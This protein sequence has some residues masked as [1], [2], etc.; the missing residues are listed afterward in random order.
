M[1]TRAGYQATRGDDGT[2]T[3]HRVPIF[4][5][6]ARGDMTFDRAW[7]EAAVVKAQQA[8]RE[9]Y[10]PPLH[11]RH[12]EAATEAADAVRAAGFFRITGVEQMTFKGAPRLAVFADL[13]ITDPAAQADVLAKRLPYRSVEIFDVGAPAIDSLALLDHEAPFLELPMLMVSQVAEAPQSSGVARATMSLD[14]IDTVAATFRRGKRAAILM[15][16]ET[17]ADEIKK[18]DDKPDEKQSAEGGADVGAI[19]KAI[20]SGAISVKDMDAIVAAIQEQA[21]GS[22]QEP[23]EEGAEAAVPSG[24][25]SMSKDATTMTDESKTALAKLA[26]ENE[27]LRA[28][29]DAIEG[30]SK[31]AKA[32]GAAMKRLADRPLGSGIEERLTKFHREHGEKAFEEHV[33]A[34]EQAVGVEPRADAAR[35]AAFVAQA[36]KVPEVAMKWQK[37]GVEAVDRAAKFAREWEYLR[38]RTRLTQE[39]YVANNMARAFKAA[40]LN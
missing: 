39:A 3:I 9:G 40:E 31:R 5:E 14:A 35:G 27:A 7:I 4:V 29:L 24:A 20:K 6:C 21:A 18:S 22:E 13:V 11:I 16:E 10:L 32:V 8:E 25:A 23:K 38:G 26:G 15:R 28:R 33:A 30:E 17:M 2:L 34:I 1:Q 19:V 12:H 37:D 36:G